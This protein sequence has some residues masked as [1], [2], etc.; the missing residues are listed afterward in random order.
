MIIE[1]KSVP[2]LLKFAGTAQKA[3]TQVANYKSALDTV[4]CMLV[5]VAARY[6]PNTDEYLVE[7][8]GDW[9]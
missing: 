7:M 5:I 9:V 6:D 8:M 4:F 1:V 3:K 2:N